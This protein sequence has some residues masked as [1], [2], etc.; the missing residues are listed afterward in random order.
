MFEG[1]KPEMCQAYQD[2]K[3]EVYVSSEEPAFL[4][5][6]IFCENNDRCRLI[7]ERLEG[8]P[9]IYKV[10]HDFGEKKLVVLFTQY[11]SMSRKTPI[12]QARSFL[13]LVLSNDV[14]THQVK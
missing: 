5:L 12:P 2:S 11:F 9:E 14:T 6:F 10:L 7:K 13:S 3:P 1:Q 4:R 8:Q